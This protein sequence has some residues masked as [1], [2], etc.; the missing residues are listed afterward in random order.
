MHI[1]I[2]GNGIIALSAAFRLSKRIGSKDKITIIGKQ[3]REGS[4]TLA[5]AAMLNSF[6]EVE[7]GALENQID[8]YRF[9]L[10]HLAG[11]MWPKYEMELIEAA[12]DDLPKGCAGCLG[13][14]GGGCFDK[15]TYVV[16]NTAA[17]ELD[18]ENFDAIL[19]ALKDFNEPHKLVS[20]DE[21]PN[22]KPEKRFRATRAVYIYDEGWFN[23]R[24]MLEKHD[25]ILKAHPQ[26]EI[27]DQ[28]VA[29]LVKDGGR[30]EKVVLDDGSSIKSD[31]VLLASGASVTD[32]LDKSN[33]GIEMQ[34]LFYGVGVS[35]E[36]KSPD[37]PQKK[38]VR[39][40]NRGLACGL[41][42]VPYYR[43]PNENHDHILIGSSNFI[44][45]TPYPYG[46]LK[47]IE[48][49]MKGSIQELN[50]GFD[51]ADFVRA[52]V[53]WRPISQDTFPLV[54]KTSIDNLIVA[55]GT[56]RDGFH[57]APLLS[58]YLADILLGKEIDKRFS[59]FAPERK[60]ITTL[61]RQDAINKSVKHFMSAAY[62][63]GFESP[64]SKMPDKIMQMYR[65][66]LERVHDKVGAVD[67]GI[68]TEMVDMYRY[69]HAKTNVIHK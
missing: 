35:I 47:S 64:N 67:W 43:S 69:G 14:E 18:D 56:R 10:S 59:L 32:I 54:G 26:V 40:P 3:S 2:I 15:G 8:L 23:P 36:I 5:A 63:H 24:L 28:H 9:E 13:C 11:R 45:P 21:I 46:R 6:A 33:V 52:N 4:A 68:P 34:R 12:G 30:I 27:I 17:D 53:G 42:A 39:T 16:N 37:N 60:I 48:Y 20:P 55:T 7:A 49:L 22:Y 61:T 19:K 57:M 25:N 65:D 29:N 50:S 51:R 66:D 1:I 44:S 62:Q 58:E 31:M 41:Y 38:C